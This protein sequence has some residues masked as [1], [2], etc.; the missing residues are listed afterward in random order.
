MNDTIMGSASS[1]RGR[2]QPL[3]D[4]EAHCT[5]RLQAELSRRAGEGEQRYR[6]TT[7]GLASMPR[8]RLWRLSRLV[9]RLVLSGGSSS[10]V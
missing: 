2:A 1:Q 4:R 7:G 10:G 6:E 3:E 9:R 8:S 5:L